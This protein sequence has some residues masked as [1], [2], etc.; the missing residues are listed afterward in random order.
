MSDT[1]LLR[2]L[3]MQL[4]WTVVGSLVVFFTWRLSVRHY[5]AVGN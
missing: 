3:G 2:G 1:Q 4:V 5:S